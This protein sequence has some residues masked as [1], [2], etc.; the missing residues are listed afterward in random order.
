MVRI[1]YDRVTCY[2][3]T[4]VSSGCNRTQRMNAMKRMIVHAEGAASD[5]G[6]FIYDGSFCIN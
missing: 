3:S 1:V 6:N 4:K 2:H 5:E